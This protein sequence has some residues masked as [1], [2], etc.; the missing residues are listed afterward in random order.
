MSEVDRYREAATCEGAS[1]SD[2][3]LAICKA[4]ENLCRPLACAD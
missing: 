3:E 4:L 1:N 2:R